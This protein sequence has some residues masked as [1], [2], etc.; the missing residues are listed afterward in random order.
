MHLFDEL[1]DLI[2]AARSGRISRREAFLR[3]AALRL[4]PAA[5][6]MLARAIPSEARIHPFGREP[7]TRQ[8][9][10]DFR[11]VPNR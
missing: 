3:S 4:T 11:L 9:R 10:F 2:D 1:A 6:L 8:P 7:L 5:S